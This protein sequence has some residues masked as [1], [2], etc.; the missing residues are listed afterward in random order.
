M[1]S[2]KYGLATSEIATP[3]E[4]V[5]PPVTSDRAMASPV[6]PVAAT[7]SSTR[8]FA[9]SET[10]RVSLTTC[11]TVVMDTPAS[12]AMCFIVT[13]R[14]LHRSVECAK[15]F[16]NGTQTFAQTFAEAYS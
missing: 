1:S 7:A 8:A 6:Y 16:E 12:A 15:C 14:E 13:K 9:S 4:R 3:S 2:A 10:A 11:E 5:P